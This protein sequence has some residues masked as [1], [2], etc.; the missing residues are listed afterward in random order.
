MSNRQF[1]VTFTLREL[2]GEQ[3]GVANVKDQLVQFVRHDL[4]AEISHPEYIIDRC[5]CNVKVTSKL[6]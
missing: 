2:K 5:P 1:T 6:I 4:Y 3:L